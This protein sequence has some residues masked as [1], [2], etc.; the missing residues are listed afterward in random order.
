[1]CVVKS[2][3]VYDFIK[4]S[5]LPIL[6]HIR[7]LE[8]WIAVGD[9]VPLIEKLI[10]TLDKE[11]FHIEGQQAVHRNATVEQTAQLKGPLIIGEG[12]FVANGA[13]LRDGV[14]LDCETVVGHCGEL[15]TSI[16]FRKSKIA[17]LNFVGDS[18]VGN[19]AN[20]EA[21]AIIANY[22]N[23]LEDKEIQVSVDGSLLRTGVTKFGAV[24]GDDAKI[25]A[26]AVLAPG[27]LL[28]PGSVIRRGEVFDRSV[29]AGI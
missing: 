16:M 1:M 28:K 26:N 14:I 13:L 4:C 2:C 12:C 11:E 20:I 5:G 19:G 22:R 27:S 17:H 3:C 7:D 10:P 9:I 18:L 6:S 21:G 15:K 23:E 24:V 25:G 8:P 29:E